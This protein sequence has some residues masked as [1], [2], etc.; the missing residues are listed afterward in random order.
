MMLLWHASRERCGAVDVYNGG[1][2][3]QISLHRYSIYRGAV[4]TSYSADVA[5]IAVPLLH[6]PWHRF[7]L[8][9]ATVIAYIAA[10]FMH[11]AEPLLHISRHI[12]ASLVYVSRRSYSLHRGV[13]MA[14]VVASLAHTSWG[15]CGTYRGVVIV[16][17]AARYFLLGILA[18]VLRVPW[19]RYSVRRSTV[20][21]Y[22]AALL[23]R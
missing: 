7:C 5:Y 13:Y 17:I 23:W 1:P 16:S 15:R 10:P 19:R 11:I 12:M 3:L 14:C 18:S 8:Y 21:P 22:M 9:R 20:A 6:T 2:L 4:G